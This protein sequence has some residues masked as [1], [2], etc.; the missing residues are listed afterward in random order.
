MSI[1]FM[2]KDAIDRAKRRYYKHPH[3]CCN[4]IKKPCAPC[5]EYNGGI[6]CQYAVRPGVCGHLFDV[7]CSSNRGTIWERNGPEIGFGEA[8]CAS[9]CVPF[10]E[11]KN[12]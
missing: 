6:P 2:I 3:R 8:R 1:M 10:R 12:K 4:D 11:E 9:D 7:L 5:V